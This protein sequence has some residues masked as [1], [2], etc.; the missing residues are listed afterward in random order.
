MTMDILLDFEVFT[1]TQRYLDL[2][3]MLADWGCMGMFLMGLFGI[4]A[5]GY[6]VLRFT[7][8]LKGVDMR[9]I[10]NDQFNTH[11]GLSAPNIRLPDE[12]M[13]YNEADTDGL[14][15]LSPEDAQRTAWEKETPNQKKID[16]DNAQ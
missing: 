4:P 11:G 15:I 14:S 3:T 8:Q 13:G 12:V 1:E 10:T 2:L 9:Q 16:F 7:S 6:N 5:Y